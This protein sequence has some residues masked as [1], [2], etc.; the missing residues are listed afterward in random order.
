MRPLNAAFDSG[1]SPAT[2]APMPEGRL[3]LAM[4][5]H[6]IRNALQGVYGGLGAIEAEALPAEVQEQLRR[7]ATAARTIEA[8]SESLAGAQDVAVNAAVPDGATDLGG[9]LDSFERRWA[10]E[11]QAKGL[12]FEVLAER[13][14]PTTLAADELALARVL[15]NLASNSIAYSDRGTVSLSV[16]RTADRGIVF[17]LTDEGPGLNAAMLGT[18]SGHDAR[19]TGLAVTGHGLGLRIVQKLSAE[20]GA[21][22]SIGNRDSGGVVAVLELPPALC[23]EAPRPVP[24][25]EEKPRGLLAGLRILL[26]EDNPTNQMVATQMLNMLE[27]EVTLSSDGIEA[28][29]RFEEAEFDLVVVDIEM[30]RMTGLDV[31]R[32]IRS[33]HDGRQD[34]P[35]VAL[36]AYALREH[37]DRIAGAGANGL[38]SKPIASIDALAKGL[39]DHVRRGNPPAASPV[40]ALPAADSEPVVDLAIYDAL[41]EAIGA[42]MMSELLEKVVADLGSARDDLASAVDPVERAPIRSASHIL[43]SVAGAIG[44]NRL[45]RCARKLNNAAHDEDLTGIADL[46]RGCIDEIDAAVS[47][48][49]ARRTDT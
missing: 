2:T 23:L 9:F 5:A 19:V 38:I 14:L 42:E 22:I 32:A 43:I 44:A 37:R 7:I 39:V 10:S 29:E 11:A 46:V 12:N 13:N 27:A 31:I 34:T 3:E 24:R 48:A 26:A 40:A 6:D 17:R 36:T 4:L 21:Q 30:P 33:R 45:Q 18:V 1:S 41:A 28:L 20:I 35:I 16:R 25:A 49:E 15:G 8:L 47:Y